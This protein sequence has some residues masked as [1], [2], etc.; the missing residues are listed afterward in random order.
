MEPAPAAS[1]VP[2]VEARL[3][4][5]PMVAA[6]KGGQPVVHRQRI[7][8]AWQRYP[9]PPGLTHTRASTTP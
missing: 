3:A 9:G 4:A 2:L 6:R 7:E 8:M 5:S 1:L